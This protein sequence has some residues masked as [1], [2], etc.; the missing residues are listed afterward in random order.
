[1]RKHVGIV[2]VAAC[3][4]SSSVLAA[5]DWTFI[6]GTYAVTAKDCKL[7]AKRR[8]FSKELVKD[9]ES[10]VLTREGITSMRETHCRFR[11][12]KRESGATPGWTLKAQCEEMGAPSKTLDVISVTVRPDGALVVKSEDVFGPEPLIFVRCQN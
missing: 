6:S 8:P 11:S 2:L 3:V 4:M 10:E 12:S 7:L 1:M 9:L 5:D